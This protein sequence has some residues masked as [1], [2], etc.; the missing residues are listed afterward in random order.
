MARWWSDFTAWAEQTVTDLPEWLWVFAR[1]ILIFVAARLLTS[2]FSRVFRRVIDVR[3]KRVKP[4]K[5][6]RV[7]SMFTITHSVVR[8]VIYFFAIVLSLSL[9]GVKSTVDTF[10]TA[11]GVGGIVLGIGA[12]SIIKDVITGFLLLFENQYHVG[13]YVEIGGVTGTVT[14]IAIRVTYIKG[15]RGETTII[16]NGSITNVVNYSRGPYLA[17]VDINV[18][19]EE[20]IE[21]ALSIMQDIADGYAA[22]NPDSIKE[23]KAIGPV[24]T[25]ESAFTLRLTGTCAAPAHFAVE[26]E[27][28][29]A[30]KKRF[31][32]ESVSIPYPRR[33]L[34]DAT[35]VKHSPGKKRGE[36]K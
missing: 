35:A 1:I 25:T 2:L 7:H 30:V 32:E 3:L 31:A 34:M 4:E 28:L 19:L 18:A 21:R 9:L 15:F 16:P 5:Q 13:D 8:Y 14:A 33:V 17:L 23:P 11:A 36:A 29:I 20:D 24:A 26:R 6:R 22:K 27:L 12:Q 10:I